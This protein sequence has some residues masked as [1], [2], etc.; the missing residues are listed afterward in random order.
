MCEIFSYVVD[1][2][3]CTRNGN[4]WADMSIIGAKAFT[5]KRD[6]WILECVFETLLRK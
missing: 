1:D 3:G 2:R 5:N 6:T 4:K